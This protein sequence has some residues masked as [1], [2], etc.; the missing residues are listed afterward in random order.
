MSDSDLI[1]YFGTVNSD[2]SLNFNSSEISNAEPEITITSPPSGIF[3]LLNEWDC[4]G[5][6]TYLTGITSKFELIVCAVLFDIK[7]KIKNT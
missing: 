7:Y 4:A 1:T 6:A 5:L 3:S 2:G